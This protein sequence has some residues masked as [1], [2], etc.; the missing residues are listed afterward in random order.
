MTSDSG[1]GSGFSQIFDSGSGSERK[2]QKPAAVDSG[3]P[4]PWPLLAKGYSAAI[5]NPQ[6]MVEGCVWPS[7]GF[8]YSISSLHTDNLSLF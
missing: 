4:L 1:S 8:R 5:S 6:P 7:L 2:T 3:T